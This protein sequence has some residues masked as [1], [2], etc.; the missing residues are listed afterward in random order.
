M[1]EGSTDESQDHTIRNDNT[2]DKEVQEAIEEM[3]RLKV[4]LKTSWDPKIS[5]QNFKIN[6]MSWNSNENVHF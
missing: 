4:G 5:V 2:H 6:L 1:S 3:E